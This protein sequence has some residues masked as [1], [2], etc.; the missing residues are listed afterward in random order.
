MAERVA[1]GLRVPKKKVIRDIGYD[2]PSAKGKV[3]KEQKADPPRLR[4]QAAEAGT[5]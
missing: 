5:R 3:K 2:A 4:G 1:K